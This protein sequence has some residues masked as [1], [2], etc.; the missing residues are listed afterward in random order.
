MWSF[1]LRHQRYFVDGWPCF[2]YDLRIPSHKI[3]KTAYIGYNIKSSKMIVYPRYDHLP[4]VFEE[5]DLKEWDAIK[6]LAKVVKTWEEF[7]MI[8]YMY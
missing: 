7:L 8:S 4:L 5:I 3:S 6:S 2:N 1:D